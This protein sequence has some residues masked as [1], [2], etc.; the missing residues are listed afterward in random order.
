[1]KRLLELRQT[2]GG[3]I[4]DG[5]GLEASDVLQ[6][7]QEKVQ[8]PD[9][10]DALFALGGPVF[11]DGLCG[12]DDAN[13]VVGEIV[14]VR[15]SGWPRRI[16]L[17]PFVHGLILLVLFSLIDDNT[18]RIPSSIRASGNFGVHCRLFGIELTDERTI[19]FDIFFAGYVFEEKPST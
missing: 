10:I 19:G 18:D 8:S 15:R 9:E 16:R 3:G 11:P 12:L 13:D 2:I 5:R 7:G 6:K 14:A 1:M 4:G 17:Q